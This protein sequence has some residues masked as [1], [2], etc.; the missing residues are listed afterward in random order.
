MP[1]GVV[2]HP[3][4][5]PDSVTLGP[6]DLLVLY[7]DG[8]VDAIDEIEEEFGQ[9]RLEGV[10]FGNREKSAQEVVDSILAAVRDHT[11]DAPLLDDI[12]LWVLKRNIQ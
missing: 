10:L 6:G 8:V 9:D 4:I 3:P 2:E 7:T 1:L 12:T 5:E 11:S